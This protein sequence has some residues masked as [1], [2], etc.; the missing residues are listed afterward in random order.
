MIARNS[1]LANEKPK[2]TVAETKDD[3]VRVSIGGRKGATYLHRM[4]GHMSEETTR[5]TAKYYD[6]EIQGKFD[7][8]ESCLLGKARQKN[9]NKESSHI[10]STKP[11]EMMYLD[12]SSIK[13]D[14]YGGKK[15]L[16][17]DC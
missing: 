4:F 16:V 2:R 13:G 8:C 3:V 12:I 6:I 7:P 10:K 11:G 5:K 9:T 15:I 14:S 17:I 1:T